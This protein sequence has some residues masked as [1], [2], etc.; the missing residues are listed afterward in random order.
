V[1][2]TPGEPDEAEPNEPDEEPHRTGERQAAINQEL[3]PPA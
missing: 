1:A 2:V 3:D